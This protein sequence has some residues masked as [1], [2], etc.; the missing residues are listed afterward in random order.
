MEFEST[1]RIKWLARIVVVWAVLIVGRLIQLQVIQKES[2]RQA[3]ISQQERTLEIAAPRG[4]ILD[5]NGAR[6]AMSVPCDSV[7]VN[8]RN[9][10]DLAI[11]SEILGRILNL[12]SSELF[13]KLKVQS[14]LNKGFMW[15]KRKISDEEA[16]RLRALKL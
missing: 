4:A 3:A 7:C 1:A 6:L 16:Q 8:P 10:P 11:A 2:Y 9:I 12:D 5:R 15:V 14:D 13:G